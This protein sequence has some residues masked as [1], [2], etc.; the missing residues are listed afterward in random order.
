MATTYPGNTA[1]A[2]EEAAERAE[3]DEAINAVARF[4]LEEE[5]IARVKCEEEEAAAEREG[6]SRKKAK[7]GW[8]I[9][10]WGIAAAVSTLIWHV[11]A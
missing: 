8:G 11:V 6:A 5:A 9:P 1:P 7:G 10:K 4:K 2:K 3:V